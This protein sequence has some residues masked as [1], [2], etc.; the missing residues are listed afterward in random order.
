M[1]AKQW[2][3]LI[4]WARA[5]G[6]LVVAVAGLTAGAAALLWV[7]AFLLA[8]WIGD[9]VD[10]A[11]AR[12]CPWAGHTWIGDHDLECDM[13]VAA[14]LLAYLAFAGLVDPRLAVAYAATAV[15]ILALASWPRSL[16]MLCQAPVYGGVILITMAK[17]P[18]FAI[19][20]VLWPLVAVVITWPRF[21]KTVVPEFL[22]GLHSLRQHA[23]SARRK[24]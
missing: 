9:L 11:L 20:L 4:T 2:A 1:N 12:R 8:N 24:V 15:V 6:A 10:G 22:A 17:A 18:S 23:R 21:P 7:A 14:C 13:W 5:A 19:W 16:G 3:D